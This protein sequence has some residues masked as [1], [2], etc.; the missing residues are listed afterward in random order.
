MFKKQLQGACLLSLIIIFS[1]GTG[2]AQSLVETP[3]G[4]FS[5]EEINLK[6][7]AFDKEADAVVIHHA[8]ISNYNDEY[9]LITRHRIKFKILKERGIERGNIK[10][11][12]YSEDNFESIS[13]I[14][15]VILTYN[16]T[17]DLIKMNLNSRNVYRRKLNNYYSEVSFAMPNV[18]T[19]SIIEYSYTST[20]KHYGGLKHWY[21][22]EEMPVMTSSYQLYILPRSEFAYSV[23]KS[24]RFLV[25]IKPN[26][27]AG[28][29]YYEMNNIPGLRDEQFMGS[30]KDYLQR[31]DF[32][33]SGYNSNGNM[34]KYTNTWKR[35]SNE[36]LTEKYFGIQ[37]NKPLEGV[38]KDSWA[39]I[40][41][42]FEKM[43]QIHNYVR[44]TMS[45]DYVYSKYS[46]NVKNA[47]ESKKGNTGDINLILINILKD[48][49]L[50]VS[51]ML[52]SERD[53]GKVDTTYPFLD[54]FNKVVAYV[55]IG[56]RSYIIDGT[57]RQ[58]PSHLIPFD[59]LNTKGFIIDKKNS[60]F[61][62]ITDTKAKNL[63][64]VSIKGTIDGS[65][66]MQAFATVN[67]YD[68]SKLGKRGLYANNKSNYQEDFIKSYVGLVLD[69][70]KV[71]G[72]ESDSLP[73][74]HSFSFHFGLNKLGEYHLLPFNLFTDFISNPFIAENRFSNI[75]FGTQSLSIIN[76]TYSLPE[77]FQP[78]SLPKNLKLVTPDN[79]MVAYRE[80][81]KAD[82]AIT[83][84]LRIE[85][86]KSE[87]D[88]EEYDMIKGFYKQLFD[89]LNEPVLLKQKL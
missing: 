54:Q 86:N 69:S 85:I 18:K 84:G 58:T 37:I 13:D 55:T 83:I 31:V 11:R 45:W 62:T 23:Y 25:N 59:L 61:L 26:S 82:N 71:D 19:G 50:D 27:E 49:E 16:D 65:G 56:A 46:D 34:V 68:Y 5:N 36:L 67:N 87:Y 89:A 35:L 29:I 3:I 53:N 75:N 28:S 78:E 48:A 14:Q 22:Q 72:V 1:I 7:C 15:A 32:Q 21:F 40:S 2:R 20:M 70:F 73:L 51:P 42:P 64:M 38:P 52:V 60:R 77:N 74:A 30:A 9:N 43:R 12:F 8:A 47:F 24:P 88:A 57:D 63:N 4:D 39:N 81:K 17:K 66:K 80:I 10:I 6:E 41:S 44:Y 79:S 33:L 76:E